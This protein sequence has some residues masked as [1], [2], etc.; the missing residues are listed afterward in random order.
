[1][2][3]PDIDCGTHLP[4]IVVAS[5]MGPRERKVD[6]GKERFR[7]GSLGRMLR[8]SVMSH[9]AGD[10]PCAG[11]GPMTGVCIDPPVGCKASSTRPSST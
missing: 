11:I 4:N 10:P 7:S 5:E 2:G 8:S 1:M 9:H 3:C 6:R